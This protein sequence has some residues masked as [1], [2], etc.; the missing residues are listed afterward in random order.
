MTGFVAEYYSPSRVA[1]TT[2]IEPPRQNTDEAFLSYVWKIL[3]QEAEIRVGVVEL[4]APKVEEENNEETKP[5]QRK[6]P[7]PPP[8]THAI[9]VLD[10][11]ETKLGRDVLME[12]YGVDLRMSVTPEVAL[13]GLTGS[14]IIVSPACTTDRWLRV[15]L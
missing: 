12:R 10:V 2:S 5:T 6:Q 9:R 3:T 15:R 13:I 7:A 8:P 4:A 11:S 1:A 14:H